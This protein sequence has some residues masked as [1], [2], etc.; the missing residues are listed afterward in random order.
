MRFEILI[1]VILLSLKSCYHGIL[2]KWTLIEH[3]ISLVELDWNY[4]PINVKY[5]NK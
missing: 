3:R 2:N 5:I 1:L 4:V